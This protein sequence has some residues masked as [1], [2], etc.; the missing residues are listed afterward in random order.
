[1][2]ACM[3]DTRN[4]YT[5][6]YHIWSH[7]FIS[8]LRGG[9]IL[10]SSTRTSPSGILFRH[11]WMMCRLCRISSTRHRYLG[12]LEDGERS[13]YSRPTVCVCVINMLGIHI[14][15]LFICQ[16]T[17]AKISRVM[18]CI[19]SACLSQTIQYNCM[20]SSMKAWIL[21]EDQWSAKP[22]SLDCLHIILTII[23]ILLYIHT[24]KRYSC[25]YTHTHLS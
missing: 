21:T 3:H 5:Y 10:A 25:K 13:R 19:V 24:Y 22:C 2:H 9:M 16:H 12:R 7:T 4:I 6:M 15:N 20:V 14:V 18:Q 8:A 11:W 1:M 17:R 23:I